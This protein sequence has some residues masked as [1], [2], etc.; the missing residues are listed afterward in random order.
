MQIIIP[1]LKMR[2]FKS[3]SLS[4]LTSVRPELILILNID[5]IKNITNRNSHSKII[6]NLVLTN[7]HHIILG[8]TKKENNGLLSFMHTERRRA[9]R[10]FEKYI[11]QCTEHLSCQSEEL[12]SLQCWES[13]ITL[14]FIQPLSSLLIFIGFTLWQVL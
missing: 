4:N 7:N 10:V 8:E 11:H 2:K 14:D 12:Q 1:T 3:E 9:L 6:S 13:Q 5:S